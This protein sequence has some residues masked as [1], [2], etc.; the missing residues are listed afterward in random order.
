[1]KPDERASFLCNHANFFCR[2]R[3]N[4]VELAL[5]MCELVLENRLKEDDK[6]YWKLVVEEIYKLR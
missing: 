3:S 4:A 1:M 6:V 2:D 5:L